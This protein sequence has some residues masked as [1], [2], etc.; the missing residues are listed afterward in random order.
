MIFIPNRRKPTH[1][2]LQGFS[3]VEVVLAVGIF[4]FVIVAVMGL[5]G[6][7]TRSIA[8]IEHRDVA[9]SLGTT[10]LLELRRVSQGQDFDAFGTQ[11]PAA[12]ANPNYISLVASAD[13]S[14]VR[15]F[16][17]DNPD[18]PTLDVNNA[19]DEPV[20]GIHNRDRFFLIRVSRLVMDGVD[21]DDDLEF[22][23]VVA[24]I[25][26]PLQVPTG[27]APPPD[28]QETDLGAVGTYRVVSP[29]QRTSTNFNLVIRP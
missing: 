1:R 22:I 23:P 8:D 21:S 18:D 20:P 6:P 25:F 4:A 11:I 24:Q 29:S 28:H 12:T 17:E 13:G 5:I 16:N 9:A 26:W 7:T 27:A 2:S 10:I 19:L 14:V 15:L 3:L